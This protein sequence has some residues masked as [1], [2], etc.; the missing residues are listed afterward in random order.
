MREEPVYAYE[1]QGR[2]YDVGSKLGLLEASID[3]ALRRPDLGPPLRAY[4]ETVLSSL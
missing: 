4:M 1:F 2:R 3:F